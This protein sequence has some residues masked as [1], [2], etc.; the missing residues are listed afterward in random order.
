MPPSMARS[1][2]P[3]VIEEQRAAA[4]GNA[5]LAREA[6]A[7]V[8]RM[9]RQLWK[10]SELH[11]GYFPLR[12]TMAQLG[13]AIWIFVPGEHYQVLQTALRE[14]FPLHPAIVATITDG[15]QPGYIPAAEAYGK[16]IYQEEIAVV[17]KGSLEQIIAS[18][19]DAV[20]KTLS[21][22]ID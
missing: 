2:A 5:E 15:W 12:A 17:A 6:H 22:T 9:T 10:L 21:R 13:D 19:S 14:R 8:E 18:I 20:E 3:A 16:G 1:S 11:P 4:S 7:H